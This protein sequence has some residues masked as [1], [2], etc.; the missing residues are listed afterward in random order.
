MDSVTLLIYNAICY[1]IV[2][3]YF[4]YKKGLSVGSLI[5]GLYTISSWASVLLFR[6]PDFGG[7]I[8]DNPQ[9]PDALIY[10]FVILF[11][12]IFPLFNLKKIPKD[13]ISFTKPNTLKWIMI[14]CICIQLVMSYLN[15]SHAQEILNAGL[16]NLTEFRDNVYDGANDIIS[17]IPAL[18][19]I[20]LVYSGMKYI[21]FGLSIVLIICYPFNRKLVWLF[22]ASTMLDR[23]ML[24]TLMVSRSEMVIMILFT[25]LILFLFR[26]FLSSKTKKIFLFYCTPILIVV[27]IAF[28]AISVSRFEDMATFMLYKYLGEPM[29]NFGGILYNDLQTHTWGHAYFPTIFKYFFGETDYI[30]AIEKWDYIENITKI[31]AYIFYTFIGGLYIDFGAIITAIIAVFCNFKLRSLIQHQLNFS[32]GQ[33]FVILVILY[34]FSY[35]LFVNPIQGFDGNFMI[36]YTII[37]YYTFRNNENRDTYIC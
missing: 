24:T 37:L 36:I 21:C 23:L 6:H 4:T 28:W 15:L 8:H 22:F 17:Q 27:G 12:F 30:T 26:D 16:E 35:G 9:H 7:T 19:R 3:V 34:V 2:L 11:I 14:V 10:L 33:I 32:L 1:S 31:P 29:V 20:N 25:A 5:W 18:N 13:S